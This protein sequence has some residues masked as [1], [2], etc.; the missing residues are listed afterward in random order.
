M[1]VDRRSRYD[2]ERAR[3]LQTMVTYLQILLEKYG[4]NLRDKLQLLLVCLF[5]FAR[6]IEKQ[7]QLL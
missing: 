5:G 6:P 3:E 4:N 7:L 2:H 1:P